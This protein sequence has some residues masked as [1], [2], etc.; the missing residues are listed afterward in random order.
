MVIILQGAV[1]IKIM[2]SIRMTM[3]HRESVPNH[4]VQNCTKVDNIS[5]PP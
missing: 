2:T 3:G 5:F 4:W 1:I